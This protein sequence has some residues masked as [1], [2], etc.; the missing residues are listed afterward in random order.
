M[1]YIAPEQKATKFGPDDV[2]E[3]HHDAFGMIGV[4]IVTGGSDTLFGS[5]LKHGQTVRIR[6][7]R[8][9]SQRNHSRDS[10]FAEDSLVEVTLSHTQFAEMITSPNRGDGIPCTINYAPER[11][12]RCIPM[13]GINRGTIAIAINISLMLAIFLE[14]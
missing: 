6:I 4:T 13:P 5:D 3:L 9:R 12:T 8:A 7:K 11:G 2:T 14:N 10:F 1:E